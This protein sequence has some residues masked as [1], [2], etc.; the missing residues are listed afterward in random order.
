MTVVEI[1]VIE[2]HTDLIKD[3]ASSTKITFNDAVDVRTRKVHSAKRRH[4]N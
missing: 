4:F 2:D 3:S 1:T